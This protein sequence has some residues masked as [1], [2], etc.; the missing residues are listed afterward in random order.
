[1]QFQIHQFGQ[2]H[3]RAKMSNYLCRYAAARSVAYKNV[4]SAFHHAC[5]RKSRYF[6][7]ISGTLTLCG[8]IME[9]FYRHF[10]LKPD[11]PTIDLKEELSELAFHSEFGPSV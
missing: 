11:D 10:S 6:T 2:K 1:M 9:C 4:I 7:L 8:D 3:S 5:F